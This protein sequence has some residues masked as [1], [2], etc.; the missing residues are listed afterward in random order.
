MQH[1]TDKI[2]NA[3]SRFKS[4]F[5]FF[6]NS[7]DPYSYDPLTTSTGPLPVRGTRVKLM[8]GLVI[9]TLVVG[10]AAVGPAAGSGF[11]S[12]PANQAN[13]ALARSLFAA[14]G[15][16]VSSRTAMERDPNLPVLVTPAPLA[17]P[18]QP[19][20]VTEAAQQQTSGNMRI[21][22]AGLQK[23]KDWEGLSLRGYLLGDGKC[24]IGFGHAV[25]VA[26]RPNCTSWVITYEEAH[27]KLAANVEFFENAVNSFFTREFNQNQFD[28]VVSFA[29][30]TGQPWFQWDWPTDPDDEFFNRVLPKYIMPAQ[31]STGLAR[32]RAAELA[33]FNT[34]VAGDAVENPVELDEFYLADDIDSD[35]ILAYYENDE[36]TED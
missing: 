32:R 18:E 24:T 25:P 2:E 7:N 17:E 22:E 3:V 35:S 30:N 15:Q 23:I 29:F 10:T 4:L 1:N 8:G 28:A 27:E 33:L 26:Q 36:E 14:R 6:Q 21:S 31:F 12:S 16:E 9:A 34:P 11:G 19:S 13:G 5:N 20:V